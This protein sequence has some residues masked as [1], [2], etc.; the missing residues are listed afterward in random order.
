MSSAYFEILAILSKG[1]DSPKELKKIYLIQ[2]GL[3]LFCSR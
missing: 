3:I 1:L 2:P